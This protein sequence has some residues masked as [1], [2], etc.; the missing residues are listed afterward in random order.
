M[1]KRILI[2]GL[3]GAGKT[4]LT[5]ALAPLIRAVVFN[6]DDVRAHLGYDP[7]FSLEARIAQA[8]RMRWLRSCTPQA[9]PANPKA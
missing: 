7:G 8:K 1:A 3:P 5:Q 4:T 6:G 9:P 2:M